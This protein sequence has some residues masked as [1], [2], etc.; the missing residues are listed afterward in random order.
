MS[1]F[2]GPIHLWLYNKIGF[3]ERLIGDIAELSEEKGW[4]VRGIEYYQYNELPDLETVVDK[5]NIH[6]WLQT[7]IEEAEVAYA[8]L[9]AAIIKADENR[10]E[11][12]KKT[13]F[14]LGKRNA[15]EPG[16][17]AEEAYKEINNLIVDGMPCDTVNEITEKS[18]DV[19][20][21]IKVEDLHSKYWEAAGLSGDIYYDLNTAIINGILSSTDLTYEYT[22]NDRYS[23][24]RV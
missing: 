1:T 10:L 2:L 22:G 16:T 5:R 24:K 6:N 9:V 17:D 7:R 4:E 12:I 11:D 13:A 20:E 15:I 19:I 23:I 3:L 14:D 18:E 21:W 8:S